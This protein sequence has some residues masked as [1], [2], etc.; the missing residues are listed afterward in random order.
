MKPTDGAAGAP[1]AARQDLPDVPAGVLHGAV[2]DQSVDGPGTSRWT[3]T[4]RWPSG[5]SCA[6]H[7]P[8]SVIRCTPSI[9]SP[10]CRTWSSRPTARTVI[11]GQ[12][13]GAR[14][15]YPQ[16]EPESAAY[17]RWFR[18]NGYPGGSPAAQRQRGRGRHRLRRPGRHR[19]IRL[20]Q[21]RGGGAAGCRGY[22][23]CR[24]SASGWSTRASTTSTPRCACWTPTPPPTTRRRSTTR[25][26][27]ALASL[28]AEL[29]EAKDADAEVLGLNAVSDGRHVVL[30][31]QAERPGRAARGGR[32][33][34]GAG[35]HVRVS[36]GRRRPEVLH[37]GAEIVTGRAD[38]R[39]GHDS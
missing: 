12:A 7:S 5:S 20:P 13:L 36:Q 29:I 27:A 23:A 9:P 11:G 32:L 37:P 4:A 24:W 2:R 25:A 1:D 31:A 14:F 33:R 28:F 22:S 34:A 30:P 8:G 16:R 10:G 19:R 39:A 18:R 26:R 38:V 6:R 15:R 3:P 17:F 35:R 21:R